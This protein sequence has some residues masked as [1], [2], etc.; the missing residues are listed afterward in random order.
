MPITFL[1]VAN[2]VLNHYRCN[3]SKMRL[4]KWDILHVNA[5][6]GLA[7]EALRALSLHL[8]S[9]VLACLS[10]QVTRE[11]VIASRRARR[12]GESLSSF[13]P[14]P[15]QPCACLSVPTGHG[16]AVTGAFPRGKTVTFRTGCTCR[17]QMVAWSLSDAKQRRS[18]NAG[19]RRRRPSEGQ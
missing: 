9:P 12:Q 7:G 17:A 10:Q 18:W 16:R 8:R 15:V 19:A 14:S 4:S 6:G 1:L 11:Q 5:S 2:Y 13:N 3:W